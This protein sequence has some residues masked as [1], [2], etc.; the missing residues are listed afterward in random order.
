MNGDLGELYQ[1]IILDHNRRPR[2]FHA[3]DDASRAVEADNPLCGDH[4]KLY[5]KIEAGRILDI[6]FE[7]AGCAISMAS[8]SMLTDRLQGAT[9]AQAEEMFET[10]HDLLTREPPPEV[11]SELG[12][13][14]ALAGVRRYPM[15]VKCATLSW[16]AL[17]AALSGEGGP[18]A[19]TTE[20]EGER[21]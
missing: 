2:H 15:R 12:E 10:L 5:L 7:G 8:A 11:S 6:S 9:V 16:H 3:M 19:V 18:E 14:G 4:L 20:S 1:E 21:P 17:K 13:L